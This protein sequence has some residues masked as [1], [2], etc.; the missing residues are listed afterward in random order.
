MKTLLAMID[1]ERRWIISDRDPIRHWSRGRV[2]LL[3][4][5][6][7]PTLQSLAQGACMAIEDA[8]CLAELI[9]LAGGDHRAAFVQYQAERLVRT[10]RVQLESRAALGHLPRRGYRAG[11]LVPGVLRT[12]RRR[13]LR[14][15]CVAVGRVQA[16]A[17]VAER[18]ARSRPR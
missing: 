18:A 15:P 13:L 7:H 10:A 5:A 3:G 6:A 12:L 4:D 14:L 11:R 16:A 8:V 2:T 17:G 1:L 9:D